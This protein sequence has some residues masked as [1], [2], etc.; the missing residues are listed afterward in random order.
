MI[1]LELAIGRGRV[2]GGRRG[3][4]WLG[5][6]HP[7]H[8]LGLAIVVVVVLFALYVAYGDRLRRR[9]RPPRYRGHGKWE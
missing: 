6:D 3:G 8:W 2:G 7:T 1:W 9:K 5:S 4:Y